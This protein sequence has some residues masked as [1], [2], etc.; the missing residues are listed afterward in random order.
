MIYKL[1]LFGNNRMIMD[2]FFHITEG[3]YEI[4]TCS[5]HIEDIESHIKYYEPDAF[6]YC[7]SNEN[8]SDLLMVSSLKQKSKVA[9]L[10]LIIIGNSE[11]CEACQKIIGS[12]VNLRLNRPK[13]SGAI[14]EEIYGFL[15]KWKK[16][17]SDAANNTSAASESA[18]ASAVQAP[19]AASAQSR[20]SATSEQDWARYVKRTKADLAPGEKFTILVVDDDVRML[21]TIKLFLEDEYKV[22]VANSGSVALKYLLNKTCDLIL[23]DY[24]MPGISGPEVLTELREDPDTA[25]I[26]VVF[27]TG[28]AEKEK[29]NIAL[30]LHPQGYL[31]KP[32][33]KSQL[34]DKLHELLK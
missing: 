13:T 5:L 25:G 16:D 28:A 1:L 34:V 21:K 10:P 29:I 19:T 8:R 6:V 23:L 18:L 26:P 14:R 9:E 4:Q 32:V 2:E 11:D 24:E 17:I 12:D 33:D 30:S 20:P 15:K 22:A 31:L 7:V 3:Y 27:L